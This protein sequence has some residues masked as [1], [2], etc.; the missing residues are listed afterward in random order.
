MISSLIQLLLAV[1]GVSSPQ[2]VASRVGETIW[3]ER[4]ALASSDRQNIVIDNVPGYNRRAI[5]D[6]LSGMLVIRKLDRPECRE[7][8]QGINKAPPSQKYLL[9]WHELNEIPLALRHRMAT[10][11]DARQDNADMFF[12]KVFNFYESFGAW[13]FPFK[14][15]GGTNAAHGV[16]TVEK[17]SMWRDFDNGR[18]FNFNSKIGNF[19]GL[20]GHFNSLLSL[21]D[22]LQKSEY[23]NDTYGYLDRRNDK[24]RARPPSHFF[25]GAQVVFATLAFAAGFYGLCYAFIGLAAG[26]RAFEEALVYA[27]FSVC[28]ILAGIVVIVSA[29]TP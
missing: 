28:G 9:L 13:S 19:I 16:L 17:L 1:F 29:I 8:I 22:G 4:K 11:I 2:I 24:H 25:L 14:L 21:A 18:M 12:A 7:W 3:L 27:G 20:S 5:D 26:R 15:H 23:A 10:Q 6:Q